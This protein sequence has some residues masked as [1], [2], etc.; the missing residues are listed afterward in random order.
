MENSMLF[1]IVIPFHNREKYLPDTLHSVLGQT[2][3][4]LRLV[5]VDNNSTDNSQAV[6]RAFIEKH[7]A[8]D[9]EITLTSE[10]QPGASAARNRGLGLVRTPYVYF[11]DS[12]D[13]MSADFLSDAAALLQSNT[14]QTAEKTDIIASTTRILYPGGKLRTRTPRPALSPTTQILTGMLS[15]QS[16][17]IRTEF[18]R[19][20]GGWRTDLK[21]WNDWELGLRLL[22]RQ[23][24]MITLTPK[25]YHAILAHPDSITGKDFKSNTDDLLYAIRAVETQVSGHPAL[26]DAVAA[27][28]LILSGHLHHE[29]AT[30]AANRIRREVMRQHP[31]LKW[32]F[33]AAWCRFPRRAAWKVYQ[34]LFKGSCQSR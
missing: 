20:A 1:T 23:P 21:R 13:C 15:T 32:K 10:P 6:C 22:L 17:I 11:F 34:I 14:K 19:E 26:C 18:L 28:R 8:P 4:P 33:F 3:R 29:G 2:Y 12:D 9:F 31:G 5:L 25:A 27:R 30:E 16:M 7:S 24:G